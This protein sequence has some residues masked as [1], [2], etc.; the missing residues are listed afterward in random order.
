MA[1]LTTVT[2]LV[3]WAAY[4]IPSSDGLFLTSRVLLTVFGVLLT[5]G[6]LAEL[7]RTQ[8]VDTDILMGGAC[9]YFLIGVA[10]SL[11]YA[12]IMHLDNAAFYFLQHNWSDSMWLR[13]SYTARDASQAPPPDPRT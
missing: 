12:V 11:G 13:A 7:G 4:F 1:I 6:V 5:G 9:V 2:L 8:E 10:F 3:L